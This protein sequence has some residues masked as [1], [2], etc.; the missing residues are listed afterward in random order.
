[1][2]CFYQRRKFHFNT[3]KI[4]LYAQVSCESQIVYPICSYDCDEVQVRDTEFCFIN[5][6]QYCINGLGVIKILV[7]LV[8][9]LLGCDAEVK[10]D[11]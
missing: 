3:G 6:E 1:M 8:S 2:L 9:R 11:V 7:K 5:G 10:V 4:L